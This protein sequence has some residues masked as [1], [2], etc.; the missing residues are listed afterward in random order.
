MKQKIVAPV[1]SMLVFLAKSQTVI[2]KLIIPLLF[3]SATGCTHYYYAPNAANI[4]LFKEKNTFKGK[5]GLGGGDNYNGGDVQL[6]YSATHNIGVMINSFFAGKTEDVGDHQESGKGSYF[7]AG[8][9]YYKPFGKDKVWIFETYAGAGVGTETHIYNNNETAKLSI[10]KY[11]I[12]PSL[13]YSSKRQTLEIAAGSRFG[14]LNLKMNQN[15]VS[16]NNNGNNNYTL[17][18]IRI[19]PS[20]L[21]WE[22]SIMIAAGW[23]NFKFFTEHTFSNNWNN[24]HLQQDK[25]NDIL[26]IK[27]SFGNEPKNAAK[28]TKTHKAL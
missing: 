28:K 20:S 16:D 2:K 25:N 17:E 13:G 14:A 18:D 21:L 8:V 15:N 24:R 27:F 7:E 11:F 3:L 4:P 19:H 10:T 1:L 23:P 22:P 5:G 26:G 6:A 9:G 12:Q